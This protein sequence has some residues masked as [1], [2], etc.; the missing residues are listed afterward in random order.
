MSEFDQACRRTALLDA[1]GFLA[2]LL[3]PAA[4]LSFVRWL[5]TRS[6]PPPR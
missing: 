6:A 1:P 5:D 4:G 3:G 2:W